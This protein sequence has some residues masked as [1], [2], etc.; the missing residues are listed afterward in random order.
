[1]VYL[2]LDS[3]R[4]SYLVNFLVFFL[5]M[6][7][8]ESAKTFHQHYISVRSQCMICLVTYINVYLKKI[9]KKSLILFVCLLVNAQMKSSQ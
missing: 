2:T 1:M 3:K 7:V 6:S 8:L 5:R 4:K 9:F